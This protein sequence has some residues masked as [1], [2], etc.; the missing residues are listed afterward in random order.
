MRL[1][2][3]FILH[4]LNRNITR[5]TSIRRKI[6]SRKEKRVLFLFPSI[7]YELQFF[8]VTSGFTRL[9]METK[10]V[11]R[12]LI[13]PYVNFHSNR[14][15]WSTS[16]HVENCRW[17]EKKKIRKIIKGGESGTDQKFEMPQALYPVLNRC[18]LTPKRGG[19]SYYNAYIVP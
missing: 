13:S 4:T 19:F 14:I 12:G 18:Q 11:C 9:S 6:N 5:L 2:E 7:S 15:M 1:G 17:R 8:S 16:L 10:Y 3:N